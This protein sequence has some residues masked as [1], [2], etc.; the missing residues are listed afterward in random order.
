VAEVEAA[1]P[2]CAQATDEKRDRDLAVGA[3]VA[4]AIAGEGQGRRG[5]SREQPDDLELVGLDEC[6]RRSR[7][8]EELGRPGIAVTHANGQRDLLAGERPPLGAYAHANAAAS[9]RTSSPATK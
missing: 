7:R 9:A 8:H 3:E 4:V 2:A 6:L 1:L 5:S